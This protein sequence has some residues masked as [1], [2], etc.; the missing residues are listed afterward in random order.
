[1]RTSFLLNSMR[2]ADMFKWMVVPYSAGN[3][4]LSQKHKIYARENKWCIQLEHWVSGGEGNEDFSREL[5][6][7]D[8]V[9]LFI[10]FYKFWSLSYY[11]LYLYNQLKLKHFSQKNKRISKGEP[12][13][14]EKNWRFVRWM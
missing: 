14:L 13:I 7:K 1:M 3:N 6:S 4:L 8:I 9:V 11:W 10:I 12:C 5:V 2:Q